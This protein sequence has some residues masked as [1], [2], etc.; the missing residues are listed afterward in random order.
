[1]KHTFQQAINHLHSY[2]PIHYDNG[3]LELLRKL[4]KAAFPED[5]TEPN[6]NAKY[7]YKHPMFFRLWGANDD[8]AIPTRPIMKLSDVEDGGDVEDNR[9]A[10]NGTLIY[11]IEN[12]SQWINRFPG[13]IPNLHKLPKCE[14]LLWVDKNGNV[15]TVGE[16]FMV[17]QDVDSY[18][19]KIY[20]L[21]R[22]AHERNPEYTEKV[23]TLFKN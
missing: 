16:D 9:I 20:W 10:I 11:E 12:K 4:L 13:A 1:M 3:N 19:I 5:E 22:I 15:S 2:N 7:Y 14:T 17:A 8:K 23:R 21:Q 6:G 18:P